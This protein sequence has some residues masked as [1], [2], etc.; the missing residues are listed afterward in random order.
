MIDNLD[1]YDYVLA[2]KQVLRCNPSIEYNSQSSE[3]EAN[4]N[5]EQLKMFWNS[6]V[7]SQKCSK[8]CTS[9]SNTNKLVVIKV[10]NPLSC[11]QR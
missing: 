8:F 9:T 1:V 4:G 3:D 7:F 6:V 5:M 10:I 11:T 2:T